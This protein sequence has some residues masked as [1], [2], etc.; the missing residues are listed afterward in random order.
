MSKNTFRLL[1]LLGVLVLTLP[2]A[3][4]KVK[5]PKTTVCPID[6]ATAKATGKIKQTNNPQCISVEY[7]HKWTDYTSFLHPER[8][9]HEFWVSICD[10]DAV[11]SPTP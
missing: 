8:M 10:N 5:Y 6:N 11:A 9:K 4:A 7:R 2:F 1:S 3:A